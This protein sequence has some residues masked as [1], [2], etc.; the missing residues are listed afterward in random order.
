[1]RSRRRTTS[2]SSAAPGVESVGDHRLPPDQTAWRSPR[3]RQHQVIRTQ[4]ER[5]FAVTSRSSPQGTCAR[6]TPPRP[7]V[8]HKLR[9][10]RPASKRRKSNTCMLIAAPAASGGRC[11]ADRRSAAPNL[12]VEISQHTPGKHHCTRAGR[13]WLPARASSRRRLRARATDTKLGP[14]VQPAPHCVASGQW[15]DVA[16]RGSAIGRA[17]DI[18]VF[19]VASGGVW[20]PLGFVDGYRQTG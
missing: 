13:L 12:R 7:T 14:Q 10:T 6:V 11:H 8:Y 5:P 2:G 15:V 20:P 16:E 9:P 18:A 17:A 3:R 19:L 1:M 4:D